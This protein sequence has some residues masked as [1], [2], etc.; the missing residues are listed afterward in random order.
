[1]N[2]STLGVSNDNKT[3]LLDYENTNVE[4]HLLETL[5]LL[6]LVNEALP[7]LIIGDDDQ[8]VLE[9]DMGRVV[10]TT[11][12]VETTDRDEIVYAKRVGRERYSRFVK[13]RDVKPS[14]SIVI[15]IRRK[16]E[17]YYLWTAMCGKLLP[18]E[19]YDDDSAFNT[20]HALVYDESLIQ[21][22][23]LRSLRP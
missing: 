1:M 21:L 9:R 17:K 16:E 10:G 12:L 8:A 20:T 13:N 23:T 2:V 14:Q 5:S 4:Y 7:F 3:I 11:N 6:E 22:D 18:P 19:A 15:V